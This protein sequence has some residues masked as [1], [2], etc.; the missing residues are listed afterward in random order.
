MKAAVIGIG[1]IGNVH[2]EVLARQNVQVVAVCDTDENKIK[3]ISGV[4]KYSDYKK[5]IDEVDFDVVHICTPHYLHAE[6]VIYA[7]NKNKNVLCEK[8][9]CISHKEIDEVLDAEKHSKGMLGV[10]LQNRYNVSSI[11]VKDYL[12]DKKVLSAH[13]SVSWHRDEEYYK[14]ALWRGKW[15]TEGGGVLINQ[16]LHT[17]DLLQWFCGFPSEVYANCNNYLLKDVIE[18]E[19]TFMAVF[20]GPANFD[21]YATTSAASELPV[22]LQI[23]TKDDI[24]ILM[25]ECA[26]VNGKTLTYDSDRNYF[27]KCDYGRGHDSLF[28]DYYDC[29]VNGEKFWIN[30]EE[31]AKVIRMILAVYESNG[32]RTEI[33]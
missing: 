21:M 8:P 26:Y 17:L 3:D 11:A 20:R 33:I 27:G 7:L 19:D 16:A 31:G 5:M 23:K 12:K 22:E 24:V 14:S 30:G 15:K 18:V 10:C 2:L 4:K 28:K 32:K 9:L 1:V 13:G 29:L 25:P 6:M